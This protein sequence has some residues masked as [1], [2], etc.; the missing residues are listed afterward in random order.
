M[1]K[2][3]K[4]I[5]TKENIYN[6]AKLAYLLASCHQFTDSF[7]VALTKQYNNT[8]ATRYYFTFNINLY[9]PKTSNEFAVKDVSFEFDSSDNPVLAAAIQSYNN[10]ILSYEMPEINNNLLKQ[11]IILDIQQLV[12]VYTIAALIKY[13]TS[14]GFPYTFVPIILN[15]GRNTNLVHQTAL[16][17]DNNT[18]TCMYYEPYGKYEKYNKSYKDAVCKFFTI[19]DELNLFGTSEPMKSVTYH[20]F[21]G[22]N[23]GI[24]N[25]ILNQN[26]KY[27]DEFKQSYQESL[28]KLS[29]AFPTHNFNNLIY[30]ITQTHD[31]DKN[32]KILA[33]LAYV[34]NMTID[35][36]DNTQTKI[37]DEVLKEVLEQFYLYNAKTCVT[38][39]LIEMNELFK[40][41][42]NNPEQKTAYDAKQH[43][44]HFYDEFKIDRPNVVLLDKLYE[45]LSVFKTINVIQ[46]IIHKNNH[47]FAICNDLY[48]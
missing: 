30:N 27:A 40:Y 6:N 46:T 2:E 18:S 17:I 1:D 41:T 5:D 21:F 23:E 20:E 28:G 39:T 22:F 33:I 35:N 47:S 4:I 38:I 36:L 14:H 34:E 12:G 7:M 29:Q 44:E 19:F 43:L 31:N 32:I 25:I 13:Y 24:Q 9:E 26:N 42:Y 48:N 10:E 45:L 15:Y 3:N 16:I 11:N 37:Y 8:V